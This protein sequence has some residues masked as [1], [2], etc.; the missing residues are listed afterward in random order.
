MKPTIDSQTLSDRFN[1]DEAVWRSYEQKRQVRRL[2]V[3]GLRLPQDILDCLDRLEAQRECR[4]TRCV[5][6]YVP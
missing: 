4:M 3:P 1:E 5:G 2:L 6:K